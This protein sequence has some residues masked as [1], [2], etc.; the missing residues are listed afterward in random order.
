[1]ELK[2]ARRGDSQQGILLKENEYINNKVKRNSI[3]E[4]KLQ[5]RNISV[6]KFIWI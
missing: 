1:M 5:I 2:L 3:D 4:F 6:K